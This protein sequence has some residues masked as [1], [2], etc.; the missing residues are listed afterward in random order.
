MQ[1]VMSKDRYH[2]ERKVQLIERQQKSNSL[3]ANLVEEV[4]A[5][6]NVAN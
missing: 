5:M 4:K 1:D 3:D 6:V 2:I